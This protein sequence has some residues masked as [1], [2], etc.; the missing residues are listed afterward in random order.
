MNVINNTDLDIINITIACIYKNEIT[1]RNHYDLYFQNL[2]YEHFI[3]YLLFLNIELIM[4]I[5]ILKQADITLPHVDIVFRNY[6]F[7]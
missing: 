7:K 4:Y 3:L 6:T 5:P 1:L 2:K